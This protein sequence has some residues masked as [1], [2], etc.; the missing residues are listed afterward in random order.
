MCL[1]NHSTPV[2]SWETEAGAWPRSLE[3]AMQQQQLQQQ[4]QNQRPTRLNKVEGKNSAGA[5]WLPR[6][7]HGTHIS[8]C[9][10]TDMKPRGGEMAQLAAPTGSLSSVSSTCCSG[11]QPPVNSVSGNRTPSSW[12]TCRQKYYLKSKKSRLQ[13]T[14]YFLMCIEKTLPHYVHATITDEKR[15]HE[16]ARRGPGKVSR[17]KREGGNDVF[18]SQS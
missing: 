13:P 1:W 5:L 14:L 3:C 10:D 7:C 15:G 4:Q 6:G 18:I 17:E 16:R 9:S 11:S 8:A 2:G 12:N